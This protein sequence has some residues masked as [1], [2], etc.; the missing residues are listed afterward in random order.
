MKQF[1]FFFFFSC[2]WCVSFSTPT[3]GGKKKS[4]HTLFVRS[5]KENSIPRWPSIFS[6]CSRREDVSLSYLPFLLLASL[7]A[8]PGNLEKKKKIPSD[9]KFPINPLRSISIHP[10]S[11]FLC[12]SWPRSFPR[13]MKKKKKR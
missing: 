6:R 13:S 1:S 8:F 11:F 4:S 9:G 5:V 3:R 10:F 2:P 12:Y 7:L